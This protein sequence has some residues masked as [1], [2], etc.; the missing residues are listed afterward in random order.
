[1][2]FVIRPVYSPPI[3]VEKLGKVFTDVPNFVLR[4][5]SKSQNSSHPNF[6]SPTR[7]FRVSFLASTRGPNIGRTIVFPLASH[8]GPK[9]ESADGVL[10]FEFVG[11]PPLPI[12][13]LQISQ[14]FDFD[15]W[16]ILPVFQKF[17]NRATVNGPLYVTIKIG[18][19]LDFQGFVT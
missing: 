15:D 12:H 13:L 6:S 19:N 14:I 8:R 1:M 16:C 9:L 5:G 4:Q 17:Q 2:P 11:I 18:R 10:D 7:G 3:L